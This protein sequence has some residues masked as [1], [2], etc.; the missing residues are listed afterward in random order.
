MLFAL[1]ERGFIY[2]TRVEE[3]VNNNGVV[4]DRKMVQIFFCERKQIEFA[5]RFSSGWVLAIDGTFNTNVLRLPLIVLVGKMNTNAT[6]P[7][8]FS[9]A[10]SEA[11]VSF[12]FIWESLLA[13]CFTA[14]TTP[15]IPFPRVIIG[16]WARG[17]ET[18]VT[19]ELLPGVFLQG[20]DW[21]AVEAMVK[22]FRDKGYS[23]DEILGQRTPRTQGLKDLAWSYTKSTT[24][25]E[26]E[27]NRTKLVSQLRPPHQQYIYDQWYPREE[28]FIHCYTKYQ[29]NLGAT[30]SQMIESYHDRIREVTNGQLF[31]EQAVARIADTTISI[32]RLLETAERPSLRKY[33]LEFQTV[34]NNFAFKDIRTKISCYAAEKLSTEWKE[35][36]QQ[37]TNDIN[38][39]LGPCNPCEIRVR[40]G[41]P[42]R[43]LLHRAYL[44]E[45]AIPL[46]LIHPR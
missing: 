1:S 44:S 30:S 6:F 9:Y 40:Y 14:S 3:V 28:R 19:P 11:K 41:L 34:G 21:H 31:L 38:S 22:Y 16:D 5:Q 29:P 27:L 20:C 7:I 4:I 12:N 2:R 45:I 15:P 42:C 36:R 37:L 24:I 32:F 43:H 18:S 33:S 13:E 25:E 8:A 46:L 23:S 17:L 26:L 39:Q 10:P 35:L